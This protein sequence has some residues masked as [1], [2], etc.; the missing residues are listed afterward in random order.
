MTTKLPRAK[1]RKTTTQ[2]QRVGNNVIKDERDGKNSAW[3]RGREQDSWTDAAFRNPPPNSLQL[4]PRTSVEKVKATYLLLARE[5]RAQARDKWGMGTRLGTDA[6]EARTTQGQRWQAVLGLNRTT[7]VGGGGFYEERGAGQDKETHGGGQSAL[8]LQ[9]EWSGK[10]QELA[11]PSRYRP[12]LIQS[13]ESCPYRTQEVLAAG[14]EERDSASLTPSARGGVCGERYESAKA[15][16]K[17]RACDCCGWCE[18]VEEERGS[19]RKWRSRLEDWQA[20]NC[21]KCGTTPPL[22]HRKCARFFFPSSDHSGR[23]LP[24]WPVGTLV[25]GQPNPDALLI[26]CGLPRGRAR[27]VGPAKATS[28]SVEVPGVGGVVAAG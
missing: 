25:A 19:E 10:N 1:T 22:L 9:E 12:L 14:P 28:V 6:G 18:E 5:T 20:G 17:R 8:C 26:A 21:S 15:R 7:Q 13:S 16:G 4:P 24:C 23:L 27:P 3:P 11:W 2:H